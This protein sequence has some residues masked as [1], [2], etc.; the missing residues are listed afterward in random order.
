MLPLVDPDEGLELRPEFVD[1]LEIY[2]T[3]ERRGDD[4]DEVF[5]KLGLE[6]FT[7]TITLRPITSENWRAVYRLTKTLSD[8]QQGFLAPNGYSMLEALYD[9]DAFSARA[10]YANVGDGTET[11]VGFLMKGYDAENHRHWVVRFMIGGE[12]QGKGYGRAAMQTL[13]DEYHAIPNCDA[14]FISVE[15]NNHAARA[16]Y[17]SLG[18]LD[19]E[20]IVDENCIYRLPLRETSVSES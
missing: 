19:T 13:I 20:R 15:P 16:L 2:L 8:E 9:P 3:S 12:H 4:A 18:F 14:V 6:K 10:I 5:R 1:S 7:M 11:P 17:A